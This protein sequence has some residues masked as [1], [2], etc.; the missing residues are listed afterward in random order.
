[1]TSDSFDDRDADKRLAAVEWGK[2]QLHDAIGY[3][4][5]EQIIDTAMVEGR[6]AWMLPFQFFIAEIRESVSDKPALWVI[7]GDKMTDFLDIRLAAT[8]RD[9]ARHFSLK[10][11]MM[12]AQPDGNEVAAEYAEL[13]YSLVEA[14]DAWR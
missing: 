12:A 11:Q 10:W 2:N 7:G 3:L 4:T 13:L 14:D 8:P 1:M 9:A 6:I 5:K